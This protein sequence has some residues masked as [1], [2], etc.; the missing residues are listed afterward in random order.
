MSKGN[1]KQHLQRSDV[2]D[3]ATAKRNYPNALLSPFQ[4]SD[5]LGMLALCVV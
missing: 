4:Q 2:L 5:A 1:D 3:I